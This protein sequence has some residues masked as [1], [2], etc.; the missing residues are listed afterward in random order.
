MK[1]YLII[2]NAAALFLVGCAGAGS[3]LETV[4]NSE[5]GP[6]AYSPDYTQHLNPPYYEGGGLTDPGSRY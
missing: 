6:A 3:G 2:A 5:R 1:S 4:D